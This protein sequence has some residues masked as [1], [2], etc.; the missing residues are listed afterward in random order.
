MIQFKK[1]QSHEEVCN[2]IDK[3]SDM[4]KAAGFKNSFIYEA[5]QAFLALTLLESRI[6]RSQLAKQMLEI[7]NDTSRHQPIERTISFFE[8]EH[9]AI[10]AEA[11]NEGFF[12]QNIL[13]LKD[14]YQINIPN[15]EL[16]TLLIALT[17]QLD[18]TGRASQEELKS[19]RI[20]EPTTTH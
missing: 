14:K 7:F 3:A 16:E 4:P 9:Q 10:I 15:K 19:V 12:E 18:R 20:P 17:W 11:F 5:N 1:K 6:Q 8:E 2:I 13:A